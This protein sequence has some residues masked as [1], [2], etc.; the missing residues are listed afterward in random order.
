MVIVQYPNIF[1]ARKPEAREEGVALLLWLLAG[2]SSRPA[3]INSTQQA[4]P[5]ASLPGY[6]IIGS[7]TTDST[8][9]YGRSLARCMQRRFSVRFVALNILSLN[10][11]CARVA[12][13]L[14]RRAR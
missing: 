6:D 14:A 11:A 12:L 9:I 3:Q 4:Y 10:W 7:E 13:E 2:L 5:Q 1:S 8:H